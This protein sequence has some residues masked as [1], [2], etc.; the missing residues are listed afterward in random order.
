[1][2]GEGTLRNTLQ[3]DASS[4]IAKSECQEVCLAG[5]PCTHQRMVTLV[6]VFTAC[7]AECVKGAVQGSVTI[8][9][10]EWGRMMCENI[11]A[12][13]TPFLHT[14]VQAISQP[15]G[16]FWGDTSQSLVWQSSCTVRH[17]G[18]SSMLRKSWEDSSYSS[19]F[20]FPGPCSNV[21]QFIC[22]RERLLCCWLWGP[23][24]EVKLSLNCCNHLIC[25]SKASVPVFA[26]FS[27]QHKNGSQVHK[28]FSWELLGLEALTEC[29]TTLVSRNIK[30]SYRHFLW[31]NLSEKLQ[32]AGKLLHGNFERRSWDPRYF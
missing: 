16:P 9:M 10:G 14:K 28:S 5:L 29:E 18:C 1:M 2:A 23:N 30:F 15:V 3:G 27:W 20:H 17:W 25:V 31:V 11:S 22:V 13:V 4:A 32:K 8:F 19:A 12:I 26:Q 24:P 21:S 6:T 7:W